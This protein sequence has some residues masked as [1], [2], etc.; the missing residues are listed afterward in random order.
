MRDVY[1][2]LGRLS[3]ALLLC[4][5]ALGAWL[6]I[7]VS[8]FSFDGFMIFVGELSQR[9]AGMSQEGQAIFRFQVYAV[10]AALAFGFMLLSFAAR[11]PSFSY[12]LKKENGRWIT[13]VV[14]PHSGTGSS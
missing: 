4:P 2:Y 8:G 12:R 7:G 10:W 6:I 14:D 5:V 11:P 13:N 9:Y 1:D 3:I